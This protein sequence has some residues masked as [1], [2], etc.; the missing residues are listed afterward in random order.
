MPAAVPLAENAV[1]NA[2]GTYE[3]TDTPALPAAEAFAKAIAPT[4]LLA[5]GRAAA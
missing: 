2:D 5:A 1:R 3:P 4:P